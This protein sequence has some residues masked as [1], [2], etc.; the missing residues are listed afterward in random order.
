MISS[1]LKQSHVLYLAKPVIL[2]LFVP[3]VNVKDFLTK[4]DFLIGRIALLNSPQ[5]VSEAGSLLFSV[6]LA[7]G[8]GA[9]SGKLFYC[10]D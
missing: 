4:L 10:H 3:A 6:F 2:Q 8:F 1:L 7:S 9:V 5:N